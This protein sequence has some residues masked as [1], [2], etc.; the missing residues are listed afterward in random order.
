MCVL[1]DNDKLPNVDYSTYLDQYMN[2]NLAMLLLQTFIHV[3]VY[4]FTPAG[5]FSIIAA[6]LSKGDG[7][8]DVECSQCLTF[9]LIALAALVA[10]WVSL[11]F[12]V[13]EERTYH[14]AVY[15][16]ARKAE[17]NNGDEAGF[18]RQF[19]HVF[20]GFANLPLFG[21]PI[22][23]AG[24][25]LAAIGYIPDKMVGTCCRFWDQHSSLAAFVKACITLGGSVAASLMDR[26]LPANSGEFDDGDDHGIPS[27]MFTEDVDDKWESVTVS[28]VT[29]EA[30]TN[31]DDDDDV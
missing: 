22:A 18:F 25:I 13:N 5:H 2:S 26:L 8:S 27:W 28:D 23:V 17:R 20:K 12:R 14:R 16:K 1:T 24:M 15:Q 6:S 11:H 30:S 19:G 31:D 4:V 3:A 7:D 29:S 9:E 10:I 21:G